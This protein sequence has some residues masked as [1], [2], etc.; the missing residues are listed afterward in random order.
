MHLLRHSDVDGYP[1]TWGKYEQK[2]TNEQLAH[3][4]SA[5]YDAEKCNSIAE[6]LIACGECNVDDS[7]CTVFTL[8]EV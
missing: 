6:E 3:T 7:S 8:E 5:Y 1:S 2:P 4:L